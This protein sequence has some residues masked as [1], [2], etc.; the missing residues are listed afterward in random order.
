MRPQTKC[1][2]LQVDANDFGFSSVWAEQARFHGLEELVRKERPSP[3]T[4]R[5]TAATGGV[6]CARPVVLETD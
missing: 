3:L 5:L 1:L 6:A 2:R 4:R